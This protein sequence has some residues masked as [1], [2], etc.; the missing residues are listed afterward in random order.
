[1]TPWLTPPHLNYRQSIQSRAFGEGRIVRQ[2][3]GVGEYAHVKLSVEPMAGNIGFQFTENVTLRDSLPRKFLSYIELGILSAS[4][5]GL[6]GFPVGGFLVY[7][8]DG[9]YH[10]V[11]STTAVFEEVARNAFVSVLLEASPVILEPT[12]LC[13]ICVPEEY[14]PAVFGDLNQR[15]FRVANRRK[16]HLYEIEGTAPLQRG[17]GLAPALG[18]EDRRHRLLFDARRGLREIARLDDD[19]P[20]LRLM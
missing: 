16:T 7:I 11:D 12:V 8:E 18:C 10:D 4:K 2:T 1:M 20:P 14:I 3:G 17:A 13:N 5:K 19:R 15:R 6:W 9:S